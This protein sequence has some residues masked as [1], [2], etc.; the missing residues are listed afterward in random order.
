MSKTIY[1]NMADPKNSMDF[2]MLNETEKPGYIQTGVMRRKWY[3]MSTENHL[4][5][6]LIREVTKLYHAKRMRKFRYQIEFQ[7]ASSYFCVGAEVIM[8][9][10][11]RFIIRSRIPYGETFVF[12]GETTDRFWPKK[13]LPMVG[14]E[15]YATIGIMVYAE[16][17]MMS[18]I[19]TSNNKTP[20]T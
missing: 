6:V 5:K 10:G 16:P 17:R 1:K 13:V 19:I 7:D 12:S 11:I 3:G 18:T 14:T 9:N 2:E 15:L 20:W 4:R 8:E